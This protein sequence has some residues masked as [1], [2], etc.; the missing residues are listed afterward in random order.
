MKH[1]YVYVVNNLS[2]EIIAIGSLEVINCS[3][4]IS[5][6]RISIVQNN[7]NK[8]HY[9]QKVG[10]SLR[11]GIAIIDVDVASL[12]EPTRVSGGILQIGIENNSSNLKALT[13]NLSSEESD[14]RFGGLFTNQDQGE[15]KTTSIQISS[16]I[17]NFY[18]LKIF[19]RK[20]KRRI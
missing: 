11:N 18:Q 1:T 13:P 9:V 12:Y 17:K 3:G 5:D 14:I 7:M 19:N 4:L 20:S 15:F 16:S 10:I 2:N 8:I 6:A